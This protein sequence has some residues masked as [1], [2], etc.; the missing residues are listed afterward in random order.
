MPPAL[1]GENFIHEFFLLCVNDYIH[2][3]DIVTFTALVKNY[4]T[5][6]FSGTKVDGLG[7]IFVQKY[8]PI[9]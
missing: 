8:S 1:V 3:E 4:S 7:E 6:Y 9:Q 5:K 2:V